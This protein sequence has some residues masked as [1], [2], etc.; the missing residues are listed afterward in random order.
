MSI[1]RQTARKPFIACLTAFIGIM[2]MN[3]IAAPALFAGDE[4]APYLLELLPAGTHFYEGDISK[5]T[6]FLVS[7]TAFLAGGIAFEQN[8]TTELNIPLIFAG[9][10]YTI[11]KGDYERRRLGRF[12]E[13]TEQSG[14][15]RCD[16]RPL[17]SIM[18]APF[19]KDSLLSPFVL[20][21]AALGV[22]D[23]I[24]GYHRHDISL[25]DVDKVFIDGNGMNRGTGTVFYGASAAALSWGAAVSEELL[26]RGLMLPALDYR[27]GRRTGLAASSAIF[28]VLHLFNSDIDDPAYFLGQ[29]TA[30]GL[31]FGWNVQH[32]G[33]RLD[34]AVAAHFW[35]DM[36]SMIT[37]WAMNPK[38]NPLGFGI[39]VRMR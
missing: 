6:L 17:A 21:F 23:G 13:R 30:A 38:E 33:Y 8:R 10:L 22:A 1:T 16:T 26:F 14:R 5:G 15:I 37:T 2:A 31:A 18:T 19:R 20:V 9:Q 34:K 32:S 7:E 28:G 25:G 29:A 27:Y 36:A 35:Y 12:L 4:P 11:D 39:R 3:C 24:A